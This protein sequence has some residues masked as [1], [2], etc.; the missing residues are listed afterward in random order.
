MF[1]GLWVSDTHA[2]LNKVRKNNGRERERR[3]RERERG[4]D[5]YFQSIG[6]L[7]FVGSGQIG[8]VCLC[9]PA[10]KSAR[11]SFFPSLLHCRCVLYSWF[12][13]REG[14]KHLSLLALGGFGL[15]ACVRACGMAGLAEYGSR[16]K[17]KDCIYFCARSYCDAMEVGRQPSQS[18][19]C[20]WSPI[21]CRVGHCWGTQKL[22][23]F[24]KD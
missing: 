16:K 6:W 7:L 10:F 2:G 17:K 13:L 22:K 4:D 3:R 11:A 1:R 12:N 21:R 19:S 14:Q 8:K 24:A 18:T 9:V 20:F 15:S 5:D 23:G